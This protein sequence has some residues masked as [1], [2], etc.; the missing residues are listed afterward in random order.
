[1]KFNW[2]TGIALFYIIFA[3]SLVAVVIKS[4]QY[5]HSLVV[6]DYYQQDLDYQQHYDKLENSQALPVDVHIQLTA[7][8][9][10]EIQL[11]FPANLQDIGGQLHFM[12][13]SNKSKDFSLEI[14]LDEG[15][16]ISLPAENLL[17]GLWKVQVDWQVGEKSYFK[18]QVLVL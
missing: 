18:E 2:G 15:N 10:K 3:T 12:R 7:G 16:E 1:M 13:P 6:D 11:S 17:P 14:E 9:T 5:D 4:T 8:E